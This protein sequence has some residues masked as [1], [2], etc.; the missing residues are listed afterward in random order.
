V[1]AATPAP[2]NAATEAARI[3]GLTGDQPVLISRQQS[4]KTK[5]PGL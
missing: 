3:K 4:S 5:L 1:A 2:V